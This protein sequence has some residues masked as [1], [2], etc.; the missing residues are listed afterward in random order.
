LVS[1][2]AMPATKVLT[3][4]VVGTVAGAF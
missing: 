4:G 1:Q 2:F 3:F